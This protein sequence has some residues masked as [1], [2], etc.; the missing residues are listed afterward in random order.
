MDSATRL[1]HLHDLCVT[2]CEGHVP[3]IQSDL[4]AISCPEPWAVERD[5]DT[6]T[7]FDPAG[8]GA[9]QF[10]ALRNDAPVDDK[11]LRHLAAEHLD[12]GA[13]AGQVEYGAF[14]GFELSY[15]VDEQFWREWYLRAGNV[16]VFVTY[17][18][19]LE[20]EGEEDAAVDAVLETMRLIQA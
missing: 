6:V 17:N 10:S 19:P 7:C 1:S 8:P 15:D 16:V 2:T 11:F 5:E 4:W 3:D 14:V 20:A 13:Q 9:L 18:C 12:A